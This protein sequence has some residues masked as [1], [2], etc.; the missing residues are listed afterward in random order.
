M[1]IKC[2][3]DK[4]GIECDNC[5][6]TAYTEDAIQEGWFLKV[7]TVSGRNSNLDLC[8]DCGMRLTDN[9]CN[10]PDDVAESIQL[11]P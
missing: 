1:I 10:L 5:H 9:D 4:P 11:K 3:R 6:E 8:Y 2:D 7:P